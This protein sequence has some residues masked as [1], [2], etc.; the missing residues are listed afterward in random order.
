MQGHEVLCVCIDAFD[1][2]NLAIGGPIRAE[3]P[4]CGPGA[5]AG[6]HVREIQN[7]EGVRVRVDAGDT[8]TGPAGAVCGVD[9]LCIDAHGDMIR[10]C[11]D[12]AI[13]LSIR[14]V[15]VLHEAVCWIGGLVESISMSI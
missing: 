10:V 9:V 5:A 12:Q 14:L 2:V 6:G 7:V 3:G 1:D 11:A 8:N 15:D 4:K 13:A